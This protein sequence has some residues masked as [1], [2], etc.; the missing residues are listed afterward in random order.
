MKQPA[1]FDAV[2][3]AYDRS[4]THSSVGAMQRQSVYRQ[5]EVYLEKY[6][7]QKVLELNCGTGED[8][9]WLA[10]Q[11]RQVWAT[12]LSAE[13]VAVAK[14]KASQLLPEEQRP[15]FGQLA[16]ED[17]AGFDKAGD[18]DLVFSNFGGLNCLSPSALA[19]SMT[20]IAAKLRPG[21]VFAAVIM[22][23]FC[24]W[25][26]LYFLAK[27]Q[28]KQ[29]WRRQAKGPIAAP[30]SEG[31]QVDTWYYGPSAIKKLAM[32]HFH[33]LQLSPIGWALPPSYLDSWFQT[34]PRFLSWLD[35]W[36]QRGQSTPWLAQGA[37]HYLW[38]LQKPINQKTS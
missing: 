29:A 10:R 8:A 12:D 3:Q 6:D 2:A 4:F 22:G 25:E 7:L 19:Q 13:M 11:G 38:V 9:C 27:R 15:Q 28:W 18:F 24:A 1:A 37:D 5:L 34:H 33:P 30:L 14:N 20:D 31:V 21:G 35:R 17:L 23:R 26:S 32:P 16:V 36:E